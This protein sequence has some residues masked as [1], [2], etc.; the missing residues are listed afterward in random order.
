[1]SGPARHHLKNEGEH[2]KRTASP[3]ADVGQEIARLPDADERI[4]RGARSAEARREAATLSALEKDRADDDYAV[5]DEEYEKK[6]V[7][8]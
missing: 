6:G 4:G 2:E 3:P 5:D 1:L 7:K 8:H